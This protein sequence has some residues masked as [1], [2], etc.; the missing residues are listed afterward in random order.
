VKLLQVAS[1]YDL[2]KPALFDFATLYPAYLRGEAYLK[3]GSAEHA[4]TEFR[5]VLAHRGMTLNFP[6]AA[7]ARLQLG[8]AYVAQGDT[9]K[10]RAAYEEFLELWKSADPEIP[11]LK[12]AKSEYA[13][14]Q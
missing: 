6:L 12:Q 10:G 1:R 9:P 14:L 13:K 7:I 2:A 3:A 4:A 8:R 11:V 5:T